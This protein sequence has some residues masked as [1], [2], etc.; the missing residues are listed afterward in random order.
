MDG[1]TLFKRYVVL[2]FLSVKAFLL[3]LFYLKY[4]YVLSY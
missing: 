1:L 4:F 2:Q 3:F